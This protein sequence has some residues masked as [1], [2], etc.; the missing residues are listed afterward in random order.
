MLCSGFDPSSATAMIDA[1]S[2]SSGSL[3]LRCMTP[4]IEDCSSLL[5]LSSINEATLRPDRA[6]HAKMNP[7]ATSNPRVRYVQVSNCFQGQHCLA[8]V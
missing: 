2:S 7:V 5:A 4:L 3:T 6:S 8:G 1:G